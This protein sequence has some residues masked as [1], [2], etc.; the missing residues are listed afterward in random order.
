MRLTRHLMTGMAL[1]MGAGLAVAQAQPKETQEEFVRAGQSIAD[2]LKQSAGADLAFLP[3]GLMKESVAGRTLDQ[4]VEFPTEEVVVVRLSGQQVRSALERSLSLYPTSNPAYL[5][6]AG[7]EASFRPGA[8]PE[9]RVASITVGNNPLNP[10]STYRVA[11][12]S[13]LAKGGLGYFT[14][15]NRSA[16]EQGSGGKT[17]EGAL[18][19]RQPGTA[20]LR[21]KAAPGSEQS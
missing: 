1:L 21:L 11:M 13:S 18:A 10:S 2:A 19:G 6:V 9:S 5:Y 16:I 20:G 4:A 15:W 14:V 8:Q 7:L 3:L 17:M 12:P